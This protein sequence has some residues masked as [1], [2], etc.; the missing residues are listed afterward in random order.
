ME[1]P[2]YCTD[3]HLEYLDA[4]RER[5]DTNMFDSP[6]WLE[7]EFGIARAAAREIF[8]YWTKTFGKENR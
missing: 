1:R 5:G 4:L 6:R 3:E 2:T 8:H 7:S